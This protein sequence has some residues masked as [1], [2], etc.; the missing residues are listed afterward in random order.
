M[1]TTLAI[2]LDVLQTARERAEARG[3]TL[4]KVVSDMM[5]EGLATRAP[6]PEYRN[7]IKLLPRRDFTRKVTV[8]DVDALLNEPE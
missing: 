3:E 8:E 6:A 2:D 7:G 5:R 4:G 1:R